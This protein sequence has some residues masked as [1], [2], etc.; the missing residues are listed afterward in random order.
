MLSSLRKILFALV[1]LVPLSQKT[2]SILPR[3]AV[4]RLS[5][6]M[7]E[8][9]SNECTISICT[10]LLAMQQTMRAHRLGVDLFCFTKNGPKLSIPTFLKG[11]SHG[12][13]LSLGKSAM[14]W[15]FA[16]A[17][18]FRHVM[19]LCTSRLTA[20]IPPINQ[21][22]S[23]IRLQVWLAPLWYPRKWYSLIMR[24]LRCPFG[25]IIG[26]FRS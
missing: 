4:Q 22:L 26:V 3:R 2:D 9:A 7:H 25:N 6:L 11:A 1:K 14:N 15:V 10:A 12:V 17:E 13:I 21:N 8:L 5:A 20:D 19:H 24:L 18:R 23:R 16:G